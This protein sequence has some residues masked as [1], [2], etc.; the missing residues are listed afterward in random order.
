M[1][2]ASTL[3]RVVQDDEV[4]GNRLVANVRFEQ[5]QAVTVYRGTLITLVQLLDLNAKLRRKGIK[6][7][8]T[9]DAGFDNLFIMGDVDENYGKYINH[10]C[11]GGENLILRK[12][13]VGPKVICVLYA[14]RVI[15]KN[16]ELLFTYGYHSRDNQQPCYCK[17]VNCSKTIA[18][19]PTV[20]QITNTVLVVTRPLTRGFKVS[21][22][23]LNIYWFN[24]NYFTNTFPVDIF[25][26][27][28]DPT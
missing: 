5:H 10:S 27:L 11:S 19:Q 18:N 12:I 7:R 26:A 3:V 6:H 21:R 23:F 2:S 4:R 9:M 1:H 24:I 28:Y 20:K 13:Q 14:T 17:S 22:P 16:E 8:Y 15:N 25:V